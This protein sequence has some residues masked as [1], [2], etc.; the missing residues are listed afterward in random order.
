M[1]KMT[2]AKLFAL[3]L[4]VAVALTLVAIP[5]ASATT[6]RT[7]AHGVWSWGEDYGPFSF[8]P[9]KTV[10]GNQFFTGVEYGGW[11]GTFEGTS[12]EPFK[13]IIF[14]SGTLWAIITINFEGTV[15]GQNG[16][17]VMKLTVDAPPDV[18][19]GGTWVIVSGSGG[20]RHLHG[21]GTWE[22]EGDIPTGDPDVAPDT[23]YGN[24]DG[25]VWMH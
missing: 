9:G 20:L 16:T 22:Y 14:K 17:A 13:G 10:G 3:A 18:T 15:F 5:A 6:Q 8:V 19:M 2:K 23:S 25:T 4:C 21:F 12:Y 11:T 7:P 1:A 24:Y